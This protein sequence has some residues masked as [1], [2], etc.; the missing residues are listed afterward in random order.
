MLE[1]L[2]PRMTVA[3]HKSMPA[4]GISLERLWLIDKAPLGPGT[5]LRDHSWWIT[6]SLC[7]RHGGEKFAA[8]SNPVL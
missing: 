1:Q 4:V 8:M 3:V 6:P 2:H 5:T 7:S